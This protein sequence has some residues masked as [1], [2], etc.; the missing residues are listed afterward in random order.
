M[1]CADAAAGGRQEI[2]VG[3]PVTY[4]HREI[5]ES[6]FAV[7]AKTNRITRIPV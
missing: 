1:V 7:P 3:G 6:A 5:A 2:P 4:T